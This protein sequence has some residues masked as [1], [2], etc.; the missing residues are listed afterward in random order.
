MPESQR[1]QLIRPEAQP[2]V[3]AAQHADTEVLPA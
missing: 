2:V 3:E 1:L